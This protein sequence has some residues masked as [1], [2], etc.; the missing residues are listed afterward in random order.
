LSCAL[1]EP[2]TTTISTPQ[3]KL[4]HSSK[5]DPAFSPHKLLGQRFKDNVQ[6][7]SGVSACVMP[8]GARLGRLCP[9]EIDEAVVDV[10]ANQFDAELVADIEALSA[11]C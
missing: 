9:S 11:L 1:R 3:T 7:F 10:D 6:H 4:R 5:R 2:G 8:W